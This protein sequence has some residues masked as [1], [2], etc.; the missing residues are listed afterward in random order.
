MQPIVTFII[1]TLLAV[2]HSAALRP[3]LI[4]SCLQALVLLFNELHDFAASEQ[5]DY[6]QPLI[7][8][9]L[10]ALVSALF[11]A[12]GLQLNKQTNEKC[13]QS[14]E[15]IRSYVLAKIMMDSEDKKLTKLLE[16]VIPQHLAGQMRED[17]M[18]PQNEVAFHK[19]YLDSY[20]DVSILFADI[21]NF[22]TISSSCTAQLLVVTLNELF[23]R[24]DKA[25]DVSKGSRGLCL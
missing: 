14:F 8:L 10:S 20:D 17:I 16:S 1:Y 25:A 18:L 6:W 11:H 24:F 21:V 3:C 9:M 7:R 15:D 23:G 5:S 12:F 4:G 2:D 22:T 19:I 13:K